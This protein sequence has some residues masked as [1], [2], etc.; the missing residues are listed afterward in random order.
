MFN[1]KH[2]GRELQGACQMQAIEFAYIFNEFAGNRAY[3]GKFCPEK[4]TVF[5]IRP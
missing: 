1:A 3:A 4:I 2:P 5:A